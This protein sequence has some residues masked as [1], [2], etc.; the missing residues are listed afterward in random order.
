MPMKKRP[1]L[2]GLTFPRAASPSEIREAFSKM[3][4]RILAEKNKRRRANH[5]SM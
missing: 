3:R 5:S 4:D 2:V 1:N